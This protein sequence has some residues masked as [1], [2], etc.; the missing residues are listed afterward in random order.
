MYIILKILYLHAAFKIL[1]WPTFS[2]GLCW[3]A[4]DGPQRVLGPRTRGFYCGVF[5]LWRA[6]RQD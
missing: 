2:L 5:P 6:A 4:Q 1:I 3:G